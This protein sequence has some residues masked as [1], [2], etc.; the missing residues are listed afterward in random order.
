MDGIELINC[1]ENNY[2]FSYLYVTANA[3]EKT[4]EKAKTT[5]PAGYI[6]KPFVNAAI[7][8]NVEMVLNSLKKHES[9]TFVNKGIQQKV[10]I[11]EITHLK[12]DGAYADIHLINGNKHLIRTSLREC[13]E[14]YPSAFI[15][16]HNS[17]LINKNHIQGY[18][19]QTVKV[20][21]EILP[22]G[23]TY[24]TVFLEK[25]KDLSFS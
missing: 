1:L 5:N 17:I 20:N 15:R 24:K 18:T 25:I 19:S 6:V 23:R 14:R 21:E 13:A 22:L 3:D 4:V 8:A 10:S 16:I 11:S 2:S 7:Y 12:S 9:F